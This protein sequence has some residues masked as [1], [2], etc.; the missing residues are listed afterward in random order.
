[1][2]EDT[3]QMKRFCKQLENTDVVVFTVLDQS[4]L[5]SANTLTYFP[6]T[7]CAKDL[8]L[9]SD[10]ESG[11]FHESLSLKYARKEILK[12][13]EKLKE[14]KISNVISPIEKHKKGKLYYRDYY[15][16]L[17]Q[18]TRCNLNCS[19]CFAKK[20]KSYD[21][22]VETAKK[23]I[24]FFLDSFVP[25]EKRRFIIDLTGS[26]EP[27][28]RLDFILEVND[29][30]LKLKSERKIIIF[31]QLATNGMLLTKEVGTLLK[32]NSILFGV[33]LDGGK[34]IS[35]KNRTGLKYNVVATNIEQL[36]NKD[37]FGLAAT[38]S[39]N[40]HDF[41]NI[42]KSLYA[43]KPEVVGMKPVRLIGSAEN[44]INITNVE[45]VKDSYDLFAKWLYKQLVGGNKKYF[46]ALFL[47]EDFFTRFLKITLKPFRVFYRCSAVV[48]SFAVDGKENI[49]IC[50]AFVGN[51][52]GVL[53]T[54]NTGFDEK[55]KRKFEGF[56]A[57]RIKYCKDC[58]ARYTCAGE[59]FSVGYSNTGK[60]EKPAEV[61]CELKKYLIQLSI[62]FW[63]CLRYEHP[64]IY[65][66]CIEKK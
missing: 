34:E 33:S 15:L 49:I 54:L 10:W 2:V 47:G 12:T 52:D 7:E 1:M 56:Y 29:F 17:V 51:P 46:D 26:G 31:C 61:M 63:T 44:S 58:W 62:Y 39:G 14:F 16:K 8:L 40:N 24:L 35:E 65:Q 42:F 27:L 23:A 41:I 30:V 43:F 13:S 4:F 6:I 53:G 66:R 38:Y 18:S 9:T 50:P 48:N 20:D 36:E 64:E 57:D 3:V 45:D 55:K 11:N 28:L 59:C 60:F 19:Y 37:F 22:S 5:F 32:K 21:M 25:D